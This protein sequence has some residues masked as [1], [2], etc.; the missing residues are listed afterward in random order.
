M[1]GDL[2]L[3]ADTQRSLC[4][5][6]LRKTAQNTIQ[7]IVQAGFTRLRYMD[8][9]ALDIREPIGD[10]VAIG[11]RSEKTNSPLSEESGQVDRLR[12]DVPEQSPQADISQGSEG[13]APTVT[14]REDVASKSTSTDE[15]SH[16]PPGMS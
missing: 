11:A 14:S 10:A 13:P 9:S 6:G 12:T 3:G 15:P 16:A 5:E 7:S 8:V 4:T 1:H 2:R